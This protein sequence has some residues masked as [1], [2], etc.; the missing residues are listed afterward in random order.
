MVKVFRARFSAGFNMCS[1]A[2]EAPSVMMDGRVFTW[3]GASTC[4]QTQPH[5]KQVLIANQVAR[6]TAHFG[7]CLGTLLDL[8]VWGLG[9]RMQHARPVTE[10]WR[11]VAVP[12]AS[13]QAITSFGTNT[14]GAPLACQS[15]QP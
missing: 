15:P 7:F 2:A 1:L 4:Q 9:F 10:T 3:H 14:P 8:R 13:D 6:T 5:P 11:S 12:S